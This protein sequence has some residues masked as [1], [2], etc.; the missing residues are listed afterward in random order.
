MK[1]DESCKKL[2]I[3][4]KFIDKKT[5]ELIQAIIGFRH[6][7]DLSAISLDSLEWLKNR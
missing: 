3:N 1:F 5:K 4:E 2:L 6:S 7:L